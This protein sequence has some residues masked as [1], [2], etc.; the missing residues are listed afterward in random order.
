DAL[1]AAARDGTLRVLRAAVRAKVKRVVMTSSTAA[2]SPP[3]R[4]PSITGNDETRWT[5]IDV[6]PLTGYRRS[7]ILAERAAWAFMRAEGGTTELV[8]VLPTAIFGPILTSESMSSV[9]IIQRFLNGK[10]AAI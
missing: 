9:A 4:S 1:I 7:K 5:D 3:L 6:G 8:T 2:C 10:M